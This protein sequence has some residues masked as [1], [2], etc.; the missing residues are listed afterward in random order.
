MSL[1]TP[2]KIRDLQIKLY[3]KAKNEPGYRF[4]MLYDKIWRED[5]LDHAYA[6]ARANKGAP[7]VDRQ[8]FEQIESAGLQEWLSGIQQELRNRT[9]GARRQCERQQELW[10]AL[11]HRSVWGK[12]SL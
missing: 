1:A 3:H 6:S 12:F 5:I 7:G 4:Y 10:I 8:S 11:Q 2:S 9:R